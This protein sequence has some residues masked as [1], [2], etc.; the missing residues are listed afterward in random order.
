MTK[1]I[2]QINTKISSNEHKNS[3]NWPEISS[4]RHKN[5]SNGQKKLR[6]KRKSW[7]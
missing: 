1:K 2:V 6:L 5:S 7:Q 3:S 4:N